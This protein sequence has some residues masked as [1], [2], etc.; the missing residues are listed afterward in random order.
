M[1]KRNTKKSQIDFPFYVYLKLF[2]DQN[3]KKVYREYKDVTKKFLHFNNPE[4][5]LAWLREPQF[6]ALEMYVFIKEFLGNRNLHE[7]FEEWFYRTGKFVGR[8]SVGVSQKTGQFEMF[9]PIEVNQEDDKAVF[10]RTFEQIKSY[11][12]IYPNFIFALTMGLG[13][14]ILMA[15]SIFYEFLLANKYPKTKRY[16]HNALVFA[17]DKTVLNS[18]KEIETFDKSKVVPPEYVNWLDT[19]LKFHFLDNTGISLNTMDKSKFNIIISNTQKIILKRQ[20][21]DKTEAAKLFSNDNADLYNHGLE[22]E[23]SLLTNQRFEKLRRLKQLGIYVDEAHHVFGNKLK[24]DFVGKKKTSLRLTI[25]GLAESLEKS[26]TRVVGCYNYTGTPYVGSRLLPEVVYS[27]GLKAAIDNGYLKK[28][29]LDGFENIKNQTRAFVRTAITEFWK[30]HEGTRYEGMLPK[31]AFFASSIDELANELRPA[32][33]DIL[34]ELGVPITKILVNVGDVKLTSNDDLREFKRLDTPQSEKQFILLVNKGKEGWNCR[35]LF[36]VALHRTPKSKI[37]VLQATM[38][39]LRAIGDRQ[40]TGMIFLSQDNVDI[41][42]KELESNFK[43]SLDDFKKSGVEKE[44]IPI[45]VMPP[46]VKIKLK[47]VRKMYNL[48]EK[49]LGDNICLE[50]DKVDVDRYKIM[51]SKRKLEDISKKIGKSQDVTHIKEKREFSTFTLAAEIARYLNRS[52][53]EIKSVLENTIEGMSKIVKKANE[54]NELL[55]DE[56]IPRLFKEFWELE[57]FT[58]QDEEEIELVKVPKDGSGCYYVKVNKALL[59]NM[60]DTQFEKHRNKSFHLDNYCFDSQPEN[61]MFWTLLNDQNI[62]KVWFTGMLTHG[63]SDFVISYIDPTSN[64]VRNYYPDFLVQKTSGTY[65]IVEVKG[66]NMIDDEIV[67]AKAQYAKQLAAANQMEYQI[68]LGS[69]A[70]QGGGI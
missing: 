29:D 5:P 61:T 66:D 6:E 62:E 49:V 38:R 44:Y 7:I 46:P 33:E 22:D 12:Q 4:N 52:P 34:V 16:C 57:E 45:K 70:K 65:V 37:F 24:D 28:P 18:L 36:G 8:A 2:H 53:I 48:K 64:T 15:T 55:Y 42:E 67:K 54:F 59:A 9:D 17:P 58:R 25:N 23:V 3:K 31:F 30:K 26:G 39:C 11:E 50:L 40:E 51:R 13:K 21:K 43:L 41:L 69:Y 27:Y 35:S 32:V 47:R 19:N 14:T 60:N 1:S 56:I 10:Q 63:Q 20:H 68:V